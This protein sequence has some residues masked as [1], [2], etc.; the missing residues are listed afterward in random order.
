MSEFKYTK[1][2][3]KGEHLG[4]RERDNAETEKDRLMA[5]LMSAFSL[6][7]NAPDRGI[8]GV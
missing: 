1:K 5:A 2:R 6:N 3:K 8:H 4:Y 7:K